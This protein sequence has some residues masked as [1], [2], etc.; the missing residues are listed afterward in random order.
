MQKWAFKLRIIKVGEL[1]NEIEQLTVLRWQKCKNCD[2]KCKRNQ[3]FKLWEPWSRLIALVEGG[4]RVRAMVQGENL[5]RG[6][7]PWWF[8]I[9]LDNK[10]SFQYSKTHE[11]FN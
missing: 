2:Y 3:Q 5:G 11:N 10:C 7:E 4:S 9:K 6:W 1:T 8:W